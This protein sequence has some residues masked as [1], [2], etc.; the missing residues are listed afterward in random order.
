MDHNI[1]D[2][3]SSM[4][5]SHTP[6]VS[7][8]SYAI[9]VIGDMTSQL[10]ESSSEDG[11]DD[12][13][14]SSVS[15][16]VD[17]SD[18]F[19]DTDVPETNNMIL[20]EIQDPSSLIDV[21]KYVF[22]SLVQSIDCADFSE[23]FALQTKMSANINAKSL[24]LKQLISQTQERIQYLTKRFEKGMMASNNIKSNLKYTRQRIEKIN[25]ILRTDYPIEFNLARDKIL[26]RHINSDH[27]EY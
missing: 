8:Q 25:G 21:S 6:S 17:T 11:N 13:S 9:P 19:L 4:R 7:S 2:D 12:N 3:E 24:E 15:E 22:D 27:E 14:T 26:E 23:S 10:S 18:E 16:M 1:N 5:R 20:Q